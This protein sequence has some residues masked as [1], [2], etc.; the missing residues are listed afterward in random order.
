MA[1]VNSVRS[2]PFLLATLALLAACGIQAAT[3][4]F[5]K[6][7]IAS[8]GPLARHVSDAVV[9]RMTDLHDAGQ[10]ALI[11]LLAAH[12]AA[13]AYYRWARKENLVTPM[14]TG[15]KN[16]PPGVSVPAAQDRALWPRAA[17]LLAA[18]LILVWLTVNW[19]GEG[20]FP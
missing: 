3:G 9:D 5:S 11:V 2:F 14:I 16:V 13:I 20:Q 17:L 12:L 19:G 10:T 1:A 4:L 6:D 18:S 15:D 8:E 7:D